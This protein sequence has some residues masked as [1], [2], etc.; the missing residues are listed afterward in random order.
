MSAAAS[1]HR[2][3]SMGFP[4]PSENGFSPQGYRS[5]SLD[6][7]LLASASDEFR[8]ARLGFE[9]EDEGTMRAAV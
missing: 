5:Y 3:S 2:C 1:S 6:M 8:A 4:Q 9:P 7:R